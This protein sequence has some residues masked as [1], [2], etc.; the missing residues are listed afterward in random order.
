VIADATGLSVGGSPLTNGITYQYELCF[1]CHGR[2][3]QNTCGTERCG[4]AKT[5]GMIRADMSNGIPFEGGIPVDRNIRDRVYSGATGLISWHP[6]VVGDNNPDN[7]TAP[8]TPSLRTGLGLNRD[9]TVIFC[10]DCHNSDRS[11]ASSGAQG[12]TG[13]NGPH[14]SAVEGL[15][16]DSYVLDI[17]LTANDGAKLCFRCHEEAIV[18]STASFAKHDAHFGN[19]QGSCMKCHDPHGSHEATRL[20]NFLWYSDSQ[21]VIDCIRGKG[22]QSGICDPAG[23]DKPKWEDTNIVQAAGEVPTGICYLS[24]HGTGHA[25]K[26]Y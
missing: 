10:T 16:A 20:I 1:K 15:L 21:L 18:R 4:A 2:P 25:G 11:D 12:S 23:F 6:M 8:H 24:C 13:P 14:G 26:T 22:Q 3:N 19:R 17:N 9:T 7:N 5:H